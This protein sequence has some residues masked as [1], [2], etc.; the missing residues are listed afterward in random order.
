MTGTR[1]R[2]PEEVFWEMFAFV[3]RVAVE[4]ELLK[5]KTIAVDSTTLEANAAMTYV[6]T[7]MPR[8]GRR[9]WY[10]SAISVKG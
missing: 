10:A 1:K 5:G 9:R 7:A 3:L 2:L 8:R 4:R 6:G